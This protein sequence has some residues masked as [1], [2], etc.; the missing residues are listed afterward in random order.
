MDCLSVYKAAE[1]WIERNTIPG[2][3][4]C[5]NTA[6]PLTYPEV[7][8]YYIPTLLCWGMK[9]KAMQYAKW[10]IKNQKPDGSWYDAHGTAPYVF[11]T[12]QILKGLIAI[13]PVMPQAGDGLRRGC[14][15][16]LGNMQPDGRLTTPSM[17]AWGNQHMCSELIHIYCLSPLYEAAQVLNAPQYKEAAEKILAYYKANWRERIEH[18]NMLSHFYAYVM[19]GLVDVGELE[20]ARE[21]MA[22][23]ALIQR[24]DGMIPAYN[25]VTWTCSTAMFQFAITWYKLGN[26]EL[27]DKAFNYA[28]SL[29]NPSGGWYG[30]YPVTLMQKLQLTKSRPDYFPKQEI[31]WA[32]KFFLDALYQKCIVSPN[33]DTKAVSALI[34]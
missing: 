8:G 1:G 21:A 22:R 13:L 3:G 32:V 26:A 19:E 25:D 2:Q 6:I 29:Q 27:G 7:T 33:E 24:P 15:W 34:K 9:D 16:V 18:F 4:I 10:L 17:E 20:M 5:V 23:I 30:S 12:A 28:C 11:D 31:S 14:E